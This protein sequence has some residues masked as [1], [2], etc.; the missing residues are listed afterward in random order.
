[1]IRITTDRK[2]RQEIEQVMN[3]HYEREELR[4]MCREMRSMIHGLENRVARLEGTNRIDE[5]N[6]ECK[7]R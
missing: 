6:H 2:V 5:R 3:A 7:C 4:Q 1:M